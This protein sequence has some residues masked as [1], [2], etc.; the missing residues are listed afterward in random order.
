MYSF[1]TVNQIT[2]SYTGI[3]SNKKIHCFHKRKM[4]Y[5]YK[6]GETKHE[7]RVFQNGKR[8]ETRTMTEELYQVREIKDLRD[9]IR[10]GAELYKEAPAF[11]IKEAK[12]GKVSRSHL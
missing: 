11:L 5:L 12:R 8:E 6:P 7:C 4:I 10:T 9:M 2:V 1:N 3:K